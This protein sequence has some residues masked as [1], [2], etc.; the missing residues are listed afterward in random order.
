M[1]Q[2]QPIRLSVEHCKDLL[3]MIAKMFCVKAELISTRLLSKE[4]KQDM[5]E[6]LIS[7]EE[8]LS[9]VKVW[10]QNGMPDYVNKK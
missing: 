2:F 8:L 7:V 5:L 6:G 9:H 4:D 1:E 10:V 3:R